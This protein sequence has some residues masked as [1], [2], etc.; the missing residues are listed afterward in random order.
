MPE[1]WNYQ[2]LNIWV[3]QRRRFK[4]PILA[5]RAEEAKE[6]CVRNHIRGEFANNAD[7]S[8]PA[9]YLNSSEDAF[10]FALRWKDT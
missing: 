8:D 6:W 1:N 9:F 4:V 5:E 2:Q 3:R 7:K 10:M